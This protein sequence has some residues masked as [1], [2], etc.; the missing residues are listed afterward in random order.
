V[1][2]ELDWV[3]LISHKKESDMEDGI[4][5]TTQQMAKLK[6]CGIFVWCNRFTYYPEQLAKKLQREDIQIKPLSWLRCEN[7]YG[8][9]FTDIDVDHAVWAGPTLSEDAMNALEYARTHLP[10]PPQACT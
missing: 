7:V 6:H 3:D 9:R 5:K 4:G 10:A 1:G 8:R 2:V